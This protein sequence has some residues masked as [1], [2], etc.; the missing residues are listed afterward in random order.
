MGQVDIKEHPAAAVI[1]KPARRI[2]LRWERRRSGRL[3][4]VHPTLIP[5]L[6]SDPSANPDALEDQENDLEP[7]CG[8]I[9]CVL[10]SALIWGILALAGWYLLY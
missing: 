4:D 6:R 3:D 7:A 10:L 5:L 1:A 8:V 2:A 9:V